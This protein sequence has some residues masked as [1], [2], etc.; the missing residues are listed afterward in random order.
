[1]VAPMDAG[2]GALKNEFNMFWSTSVL[3]FMRVDKSA[4]YPAKNPLGPGL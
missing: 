3:N 2:F 4:Q 1:M